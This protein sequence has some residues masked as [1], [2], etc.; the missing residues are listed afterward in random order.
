FSVS[1]ET[2]RKEI[3][4]LVKVIEKKPTEKEYINCISCNKKKEKHTHFYNTSNKLYVNTKKIP[5]CKLC[6]KGMVDYEDMETV[7]SILRQFDIM[8]D[9]ECWES[10]VNSKMDTIGRYMS[11]S[12]S[13]TQFEGKG[14]N[15][16]V[17]K[18][19]M[20]TSQE[21]VQKST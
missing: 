18:K 13:L 16:S 5:L 20:K 14:W 17:F 12:N 11:M 3:C 4:V 6:I 7:Y 2:E 10:A 19:K 15:D 1:R 9:I 21:V 8:F